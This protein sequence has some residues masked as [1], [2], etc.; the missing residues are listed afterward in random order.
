MVEPLKTLVVHLVP[1]DRYLAA[2]AQGQSGEVSQ[3]RHDTRT[4]RRLFVP[5]DRCSFHRTKFGFREL[6]VKELE[7]GDDGFGLAAGLLRAKIRR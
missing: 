4:R 1:I 6:R 2:F 3:D 7:V 5:A